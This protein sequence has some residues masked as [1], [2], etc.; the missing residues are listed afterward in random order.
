MIATNDSLL[1]K[2][3]PDDVSWDEYM[4]NCEEAIN[5]KDV[6]SDEISSDDKILAEEERNS[7]KRPENIL[8]TKSVIKI[9]EK[10]WRSR[11][12]CKIA[13]LFF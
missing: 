13:K 10:K 9:Y 7:K 2:C 11:R 1:E 3:R 12:V 6:H 4:F 5:N 8:N